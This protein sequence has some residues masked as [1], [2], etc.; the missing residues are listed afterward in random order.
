MEE[1]NKN[2][3]Y[4]FAKDVKVWNAVAGML[5]MKDLNLCLGL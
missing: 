1:S 4:N 5:W 2:K 3:I